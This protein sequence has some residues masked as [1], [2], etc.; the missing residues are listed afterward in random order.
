MLFSFGWVSFVK[1]NRLNS[2]F[3]GGEF[4][5]HGN[6]KENPVGKVLGVFWGGGRGG[7]NKLQKSPYFEEKSHTL[8]YLDNKFLLSQNY[9]RF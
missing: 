8:S 4:L 7:Q 6:I 3:L 9:A 2:V 1:I 5:Q